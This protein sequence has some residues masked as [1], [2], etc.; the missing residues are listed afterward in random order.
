MGN[1]GAV[2]PSVTI[3]TF[4]L[5]ARPAHHGAVRRRAGEGRSCARGV[6]G[7]DRWAGALYI[8]HMLTAHV[9]SAVLGIAVLASD[10]LP[11]WLGWTGV[12]WC[13]GFAG[14]FVATRCAGPVNPPFWAHLYT[15]TVGL[16]LVPKSSH[17]GMTPSVDRARAAP[18]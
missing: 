5:S 6:R 2:V 13:L 4:C 12:L 8:V 1:C 10:A 16:D 11:G 15:G 9:G 3:S 14:G 17:T 7:H 18:G